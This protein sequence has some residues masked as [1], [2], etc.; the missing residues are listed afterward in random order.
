MRNR[1]IHGYDE[2]QDAV[3]WDAAVIGVP[4]LRAQ[5]EQVLGR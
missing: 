5:I 1:I 3:V 4:L 2:I